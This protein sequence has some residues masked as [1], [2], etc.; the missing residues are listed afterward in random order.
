MIIGIPRERT[1]GEKR[2]ALAPN[3]IAA[4]RKLG[5]SLQVET[6]AGTAAGFSDADYIDSG[7]QIVDSRETLWASSDIVIKVRA[8]IFKAEHPENEAEIGRAH[9]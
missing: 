4:A 9:V 8:P 1:P 6:G 5:F 3:A 2:V 7:A